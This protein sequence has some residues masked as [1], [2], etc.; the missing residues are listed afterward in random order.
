M[1]RWCCR[2][3][4]AGIAAGIAFLFKLT[5]VTVNIVRIRRG[6]ARWSLRSQTWNRFCGGGDNQRRGASRCVEAEVR[7]NNTVYLDEP[8]AAWT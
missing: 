7:G 3:A 2:F 4:V 1:R 5:L 8:D 6:Q